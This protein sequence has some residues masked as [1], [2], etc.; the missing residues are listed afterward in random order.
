MDFQRDEGKRL[1]TKQHFGSLWVKDGFGT[2]DGTLA[3]VCDGYHKMLVAHTCAHRYTRDD[4]PPVSYAQKALLRVL[5]LICRS[6]GV[7]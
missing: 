6:R 5:R 7:Q 1:T 3:R 4:P 2:L